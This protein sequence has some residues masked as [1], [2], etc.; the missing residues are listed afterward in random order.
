[1]AHVNQAILISR[2]ELEAPDQPYLTATEAARWLGLDK[3]IFDQ[4]FDIGMFRRGRWLGG[5]KTERWSRR[6]VATMKEILDNAEA[7]I[8]YPQFKALKLEPDKKPEEKTGETEAA[9]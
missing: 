1:M 8:W 9:G 5:V 6:D 2:I 3:R 7:Y 4:C